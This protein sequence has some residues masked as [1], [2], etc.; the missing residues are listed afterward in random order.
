M[1]KVIFLLI[2]ILLISGCTSV[3]EPSTPIKEDKTPI[4]EKNQELPE[5]EENVTET[6]QETENQEKNNN[7]QCPPVFNYEFTDYSKIDAFNPLGSISGA[8]RGRSY[9]NIKQ[10]ETTP[11]YAPM[12]ATLISVIYAYRGP[13]VEHGEYGFL[14]DA[15]CGITFLIDHIDSA[16]EEMKKHSPKEPSNSTA[17]N[18]YISVEVKEGTLLGYTDGTPQAGT[19]DFLVSDSNKKES[20]INQSRWEWDQSL[21]SVCPY[22][23]YTQELKEK[24]YQ[25]IGII[26]AGKFIKAEDCGKLS[27]DIENTISG[28][29]FLDDSTDLKGEFMLIGERMGFVDVTIKSS[30]E[31]VNLR[32]TNY[33]PKQLPK[34]IGIGESVC[35]QGFAN[36]WVYL[37]LVDSQTIQVT[38]GKGVCPSSFPKTNMKTFYR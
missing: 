15:G 35:Y 32:I 10:G 20:Y 22:D 13:D 12:D 6:P 23:L 4:E 18:D 11:V 17:T 3:K 9:I 16:S 14:F 30:S 27:Y 33:E 38:D 26:N 21:N 24:Y 36:D 34:D 19:F 7:V 5:N 2:A 1:K 28:G 29:W 37:N 25:K 8:S 31:N